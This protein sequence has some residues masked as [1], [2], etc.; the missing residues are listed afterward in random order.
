MKYSRFL[1]LSALL[2]ASAAT[3]GVAIAQDGSCLFCSCCVYTS[4]EITAQLDNT[5][6]EC[7]D[8]IYARSLAGHA[9]VW[10]SP[11][12]SPNPDCFYTCFGADASENPD[13]G[14]SG[15]SPSP[16]GTNS[17]NPGT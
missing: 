3:P 8:S 2:G 15:A 16:T 7:W 4:V 10:V 13:G 12:V 9:A 11:G 5:V 17:C 6:P 1:G 14:V